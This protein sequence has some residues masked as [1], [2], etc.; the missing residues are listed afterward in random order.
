[1]R[2]KVF[3]GFQVR[4][5]ASLRLSTHMIPESGLSTHMIPEPGIVAAVATPPSISQAH[6]RDRH[7]D[8]SDFLETLSRLLEELNLRYCFLAEPYTDPGALICPLEMTVH[9]EDRACLPMLFQKLGERGYLPLRCLPLA[10][11]DCRYDFAGCLDAGVRFFSLTI[12]EAY[13]KGRLF[14]TDGEILTRRQ[15]RGNCWVACEPDQFFHVLSKV[16]LEGTVTEGRRDQLKQLA[17]AL[18]SLQARRVAAL[19][20]GEELQQEVLAA[21]AGGQWDGIRERLEAQLRR[22]SLRRPLG[23]L[24]HAVLQFRSALRRWLR[25]RGVYIVILGPDGA[26]KSTLTQKIL[27]LL[28]PLF[29]S[30]KILQWRPQ[31]LKPRPRYF[32]GFNPPHSKPPHG[33]IE[34]VARVFA[35][36]LD[37]WVA[38]PTVIRPLLARVALV[39]YDRDFHDLLVDRLRYR[40]GGPDWLPGLVAKLLPQ[41]GT[42]YLTLD[43]EPDIILRRKNEVAPDELRRQRGA[44]RDL[45]ARLSS[46]TL[47]RTDEGLE[48]STSA[49]VRAVLTYMASRFAHRQRRLL[50]RAVRKT[51]A[52]RASSPTAIANGCGIRESHSFIDSTANFGASFLRSWVFKGS[53]AIAD[54]GLISGSNFVLSILLA[55][56]LG[57]DQ[58]GAYALAFSTFVLLSLIHQA[59]VLEPLSVFGPSVYRNSLRQYLGL[60][61]WLQLGMGAIFVIAASSVGVLS[62]FLREPSY[63]AMAFAGMAFAAPCVLLLWFARRAFYL[64]LLPGQALIGAFAY[65]A[66]LWFGIWVLGR[67]KLLSPF[68]AFLVMGS[69]ALLTSILLLIR[70]QPAVGVTGTAA[71]LALKEVSE[72][73]WRYGFW[74]LVSGLL[75]WIPWN[76]FYPLVSRFSG[77]AEAGTLRA[78]LNLTLPIT[79]AYSAF[80]MLFLSHTACLGHEGGWESVKAQAWRIAGLYALGSA[81]YWLLVCLFRSQLIHFLYADQYSQVVPLVPVLAIS[82][83]LSGATLGPTIAIRAMRSPATVSLVYFGASVVALLVGIPACRAWGFRGAILAILLS[84]TMAFLTG[85]QILRSRDRQPIPDTK[86]CTRDQPI[87]TNAE[88][89]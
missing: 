64:Q 89:R 76:I 52:H 34:S 25:P 8:L 54:Q 61:I 14:T 31:F 87:E 83:I 11:N 39:I 43:A 59:L 75:F 1:V 50:T 23:P 58:Y 4:T 37:Y 80:S 2:R 77:L 56:Y 10:A 41:P 35:V 26:G 18:G 81:S 60:M 3:R 74:A 69:C 38:Y 51:K 33:L 73:H 84:S 36:L 17:E 21:C 48:A 72:R 15:N 27:E 67:G 55:R 6:A 12:R 13:P 62:S 5:G 71:W 29:A 24:V 22:G 9:S 47:I 16:S 28:G 53:L 66:L 49:G 79:S 70:L 20:F 32:P 85:F 44:Y 63:L 30:D 57:A 78:L 88:T 82:S 86:D 40:Y 68:A 19:L 45:A 65:S 42:L 46:S 7:P